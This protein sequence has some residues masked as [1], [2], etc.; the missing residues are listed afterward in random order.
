MWRM[1]VTIM[2]M[3]IAMVVSRMLMLM[4]VC[5]IRQAI[6]MVVRNGRMGKHQQIS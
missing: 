3:P 6:V 5:C 2:L 1:V 4:M